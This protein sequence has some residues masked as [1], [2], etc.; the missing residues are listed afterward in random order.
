M[1]RSN[2]VYAMEISHIASTFVVS[3]LLWYVCIVSLIF[4]FISK[5]CTLTALTSLPPY[6]KKKLYG[7]QNHLN[8]LVKFPKLANNEVRTNNFNH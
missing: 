7:R 3:N 8:K 6:Y 2:N 4:Y 1:Y 5:S